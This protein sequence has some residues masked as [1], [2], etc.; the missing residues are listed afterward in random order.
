M[1]IMCASDDKGDKQGSVA[2]VQRRGR[3]IRILHTTAPTNAKGLLAGKAE[4]YHFSRRGITS[5][6]MKRFALDV[7]EKLRKL[8]KR[9]FESLEVG[10]RLDVGVHMRGVKSCPSVNEITRWYCADQF[11]DMVS[12]ESGLNQLHLTR[13]FASAFVEWVDVAL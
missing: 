10:V 7:F 8:G 9:E 4:P 2:P 13:S 11:D 3:V 5:N 6:E 12:E 1:F